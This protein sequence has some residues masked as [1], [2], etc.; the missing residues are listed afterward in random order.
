[1]HSEQCLSPV[2]ILHHLHEGMEDPFNVMSAVL[3][4][5]HEGLSIKLL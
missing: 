1:M 2:L 3:S 4:G 5:F